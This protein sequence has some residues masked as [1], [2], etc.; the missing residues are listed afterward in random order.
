MRSALRDAGYGHDDPLVVGLQRGPGQPEYV[1]QGVT[2][3]GA[4]VTPS[5]RVYVASLSKQFVAAC[6]ALLVDAGELDVDSALSD[7]VPE[8]PGW[9]TE[10][11]VRHLIAHTAGLP[12]DVEIDD[13]DRTSAGVLDALSRLPRLLRPPGGTFEYSNPGYVGLATVVE[14][15]AGQSLP[16]FAQRRL[17]RTAGDG[18]HALLGGT[19]SVTS[20]QRS[21]EGSASGAAVTR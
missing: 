20:G 8:L 12:E 11:R 7:H 4:P 10:V 1:V 3:D 9:A 13:E 19:G 15:A 18:G 21:A 6:A 5:T 17:F 14:R 2:G 16:A